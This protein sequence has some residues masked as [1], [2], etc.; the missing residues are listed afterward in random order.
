MIVQPLAEFDQPVLIQEFHHRLANEFQVMTTFIARCKRA[1]TRNGVLP[2]LSELEERILAF[3]TLNRLLANPQAITPYA[4]YCETL[5]DLLIKAFGRDDVVAHVDMNDASLQAT[6]RL[7]IALMLVELVVN[8]LKHGASR[9]HG[10]AIRVTLDVLRKHAELTVTNRRGRSAERQVALPR[11]VKVLAQQLAGTVSV[12]RDAGY[13]VQV[14][15][16]IEVK[17]RV[18]MRQV[19]LV[20]EGEGADAL[21]PQQQQPSTAAT[22][23]GVAGCGAEL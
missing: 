23:Y 18:Q 10:E 9:G 8:A 19:P 7:Y 11:M 2:L 20:S 5:C 14:H 16:P 13:Q 6:E 4:S 22:S 15:F 1:A 3:A 17:R 12:T 21:R